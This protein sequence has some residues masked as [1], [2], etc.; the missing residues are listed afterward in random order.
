MDQSTERVQSKNQQ[1]IATVGSD[2]SLESL[3]RDHN[4]CV[5]IPD[6]D[7]LDVWSGG[8]GIDIQQRTRSSQFQC[9]PEYFH[10]KGPAPGAYAFE[11]MTLSEEVARNH[12]PVYQFSISI[13]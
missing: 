8:R 2:P 13:R 5:Q 9:Y 3:S 12:A 7:K 6:W 11:E 10:R 1:T 4:S